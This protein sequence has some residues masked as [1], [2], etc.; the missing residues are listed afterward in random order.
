MALVVWREIVWREIVI[1]VGVCERE[2]IHFL[3]EGGAVTR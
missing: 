3:V 1:G 2:E